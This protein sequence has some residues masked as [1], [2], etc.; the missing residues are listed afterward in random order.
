M[1]D[2]GARPLTMSEKNVLRQLLLADGFVTPALLA[3]CTKMVNA[4]KY[5]VKGHTWVIHSLGQLF[6]VDS[7]RSRFNL[8]ILTRTELQPFIIIIFRNHASRDCH[9]PYSGEF[10]KSILPTPLLMATASRFRPL[11][12]WTIYTTGTQRRSYDRVAYRQNHSPCSRQVSRFRRL[13]CETKGRRA[14][15]LSSPGSVSTLV[16]LCR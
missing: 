9:T 1:V 11:L 16:I 3:E 13:H 7:R 2:R 10:N 15:A 5:A 12:P 6:P 4:N 8:Y 14:V